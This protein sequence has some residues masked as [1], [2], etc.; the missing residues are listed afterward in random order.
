MEMKK[1]GLPGHAGAHPFQP[2]AG[3]ATLNVICAS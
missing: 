3:Y 1:Y 2:S